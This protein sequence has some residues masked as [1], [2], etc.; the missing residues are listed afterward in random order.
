MT[1][2]KKLALVGIIGI[3]IIVFV[4]MA[5]CGEVTTTE[6]STDGSAGEMP[7]LDGS[8]VGTAGAT[9]TFGSA[10]AGAAGAA[11]SGAAGVGSSAAGAAGSPACVAP[12]PTVE[13][14]RAS[15]TVL[16]T[17]AFWCSETYDAAKSLYADNCV[18]GLMTGYYA[19]MSCPFDVV[20]AT[21]PDWTGPAPGHTGAIVTNAGTSVSTI[22]RNTA[23]TIY[24]CDADGLSVKKLDRCPR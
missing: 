17:A 14:C 24:C 10:G 20:I 15:G 16:V 18:N 8:S 22:W 11:G 7:K 12:L 5:G 4:S 23:D 13:A 19:G 9:V 1:F 21:T 3:V 6:T 2:N